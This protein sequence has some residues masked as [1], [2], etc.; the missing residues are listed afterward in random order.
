MLPDYFDQWHPEDNFAD[1]YEL[2]PT[3][4]PQFLRDYR[5]YVQ[6]HPHSHA[7]QR[8]ALDDEQQLHLATAELDIAEKLAGFDED[9]AN[10]FWHLSLKRTIEAQWVACW[11]AP[12]EG[13]QYMLW[14]HMVLP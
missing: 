5:Q 14:D 9:V 7:A 10:M 1:S 12:A 2:E 11:T 13:V 3:D 8:E 4:N 6:D